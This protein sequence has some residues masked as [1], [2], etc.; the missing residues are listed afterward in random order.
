MRVDPKFNPLPHGARGIAL[1]ELILVLARDKIIWTSPAAREHFTLHLGPR[2]GILDIHR[3]RIAEDGSKMHTALYSISRVNLAALFESVAPAAISSLRG[4]LRRLRPG[5]MARRRVGAVLGLLPEDVDLPRVTTVR[6]RKLVVDPERLAA[7]M[8]IPERLEELY[9]LEDG[10]SFTLFACR[11]PGSPRRLGMG[12]KFTDRPVVPASCGSAN[13]TSGQWRV[14]SPSGF[15]M[16][17]AGTAPFT[18]RF[19]GGSHDSAGSL[20]GSG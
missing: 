9:D 20:E 13:G 16:R 17:R 10:A 6:R 14:V 19:R 7:Q 8:R 2:S 1:G 4:L 3:T 5:W 18:S 12:V 11:N 15:R